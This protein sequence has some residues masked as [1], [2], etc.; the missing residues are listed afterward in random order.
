MT[1]LATDGIAKQLKIFKELT[2]NLLF[3]EAQ[4]DHSPN[5]RNK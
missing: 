5:Y 2:K 1:H 3:K 4:G